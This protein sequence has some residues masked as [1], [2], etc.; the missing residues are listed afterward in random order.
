MHFR[1]FIKS[2]GGIAVGEIQPPNI[3]A[4][5]VAAQRT[6]SVMIY[7]ELDGVLVADAICG[8]T[9]AQVDPADIRSIEVTRTHKLS[10]HSAVG[11]VSTR[12][13]PSEVRAVGEMVRRVDRT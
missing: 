8:R 6:K 5:S 13:D 9:I 11:S 12:V 3:C 7:T 1:A 2:S 10:D 4:V